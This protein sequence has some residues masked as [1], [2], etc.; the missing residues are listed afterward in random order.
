[1][2]ATKLN[3]TLRLEGQE[4]FTT[5]EAPFA[6]TAAQRTL[7]IGG[8]NLSARLGA[9]STPKIDKQPVSL[10][11]TLGSGVTTIDLTA[12]AGLAMPPGATR[13]L[14]MTAAKLVAW[15][16]AADADNTN[17]VLVDGAVLTPYPL[18]GSGKSRLFNPGEVAASCFNGVASGKPLVSSTVKNIGLSSGHAGDIVGLDLYFGT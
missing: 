12:I 14:D 2:S 10:L 18:F 8:N 6:V 7:S 11:I 13:T 1:M 3:L 5:V 15:I 4:I 9:S 16:I 17:D